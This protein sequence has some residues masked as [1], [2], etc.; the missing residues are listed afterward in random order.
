VQVAIWEITNETTTPYNVSTGVFQI[1]NNSAVTTAANSLLSGLGF[2]SYTNGN[3]ILT[4]YV[5]LSGD[6]DFTLLSVTGNTN[7]VP[8]PGSLALL[9]TGLA[10][11]AALRRRRARA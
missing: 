6:Q 2:G 8:E 10:G 3:G 11:I 4:E 1:S 7:Q 5:P 9:A